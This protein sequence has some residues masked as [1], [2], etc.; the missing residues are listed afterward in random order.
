MQ[1]DGADAAGSLAV[2]GTEPHHTHAVGQADDKDSD[3][4]YVCTCLE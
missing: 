2:L 3:A 4:K 1:D